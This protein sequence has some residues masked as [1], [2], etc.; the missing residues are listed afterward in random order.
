MTKARDLPQTTLD[1]M[2]EVRQWYHDGFACE[3]V[4]HEETRFTGDIAE[5]MRMV[6]KGKK[7]VT[8][9]KCRM[10]MRISITE[11]K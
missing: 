9:G 3:I 4:E 2:A 8:E 6:A 7:L 11:K 10:H 1:E 5:A